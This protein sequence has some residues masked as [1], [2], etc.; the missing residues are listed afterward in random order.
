MKKL[1]VLGAL[2]GAMSVVNAQGYAGIEYADNHNRAT[3]ADSYS[4]GVVVGVKDGAWQYSGKTSWSQA[5]YGNGAITTSYEA[6]VK[7]NWKAGVVIPY[8]QVRLG[9]QVSSTTN[10]SYYAV[11]AGVVVP[12]VAKVGVDFSYRYRNAFNTGNNFETNRYGIEPTFQITNKDKVGLRYSRSY[13]DSE[14]N[15]WRLAY[16]RSF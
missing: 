2:L 7:H 9:E 1:L 4:P 14:T 8:A 3:G 10:F 5:E 11:D 12:V 13:G 16:T 15:S 6:R